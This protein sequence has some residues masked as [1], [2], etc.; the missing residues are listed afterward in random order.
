MYQSSFKNKNQGLAKYFFSP[1]KANYTNHY[2]HFEKSN[3]Y[4]TVRDKSKVQGDKKNIST[5]KNHHRTKSKMSG[6]FMQ[7]IQERSV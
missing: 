5:S 2:Q 7:K 6:S 1:C 4:A 3:P